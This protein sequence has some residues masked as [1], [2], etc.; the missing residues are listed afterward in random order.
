MQVDG[1]ALAREFAMVSG[2]SAHN[3]LCFGCATLVTLDCCGALHSYANRCIY[4]TLECLGVRMAKPL[5]PDL[6]SGGT[7]STL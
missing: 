2:C 6:R 1:N 3:S 5:M 7:R 4:Q